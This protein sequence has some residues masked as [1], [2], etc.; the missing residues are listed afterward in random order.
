MNEYELTYILSVNVAQDD[1]GRIK[2]RVNK[3][4]SKHGGIHLRE[5]DLGEKALAYPI[6]KEER[7]RYARIHFLGN[8]A[9][10][11]DLEQQLRI[12]A[13]VL[14]FL[15]VR[16]DRNVDPE[17]KK[18]EHAEAERKLEQERAAGLTDES[19]VSPEDEAATA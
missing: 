11:D 5:Q 2:D 12:S 3:L 17:A 16:V 14:R 18:K 10:V 1:T 7:G 15:T 13:P 9:L 6:R 19:P 8:G 4:L